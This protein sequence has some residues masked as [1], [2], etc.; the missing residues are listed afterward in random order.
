MNIVLLSISLLNFISSEPTDRIHN[1]R[2]VYQNTTEL[3]IVWESSRNLTNVR[4]SIHDGY[5]TD[6]DYAVK[7][8]IPDRDDSVLYS[9]LQPA[10]VY[11]ITINA[12]R[13]DG[14]PAQASTI[15]VYTL[16]ASAKNVRTKF[17]DDRCV[18]LE[19]ENVNQV[20][21]KVDCYARVQHTR[22]I[23]R[24]QECKGDQ[25]NMVRICDMP[26]GTSWDI[27]IW[28]ATNHKKSNTYVY[29]FITQPRPI[30]DATAQKITMLDEER[31]DLDIVWTWPEA[32]NHWG[33][34]KIV[35]SPPPIDNL[36]T[37]SPYFI[38]DRRLA[39]GHS[40]PYPSNSFRIEKIH[41]GNIYTV[42][43]S[44][45]KG[46]LES[47]PFC[48]EQ[49]IPRINP[50]LLRSSDVDENSLLEPTRRTCHIPLGLSPKKPKFELKVADI[51]PS[52]NITWE[53][54]EKK[55][56]ENGYELILAPEVDDSIEIPQ[57][58]HLRPGRD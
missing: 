25:Q 10:A 56:P 13:L 12:D 18:T 58:I 31:A 28:Y 49:A 5:E 15:K 24:N 27:N 19:W 22:D 32:G 21:E 7:T 33:L 52:M 57:I 11:W 9:G 1:V 41:Q 35:F 34:V 36:G 2:F 42:C 50:N 8:T 30:T 14:E 6:P 43:I 48:F 39:Y 47:E 26:P 54:P 20:R 51:E 3:G 29:R 4:T 23:W 53:Q 38:A 55:H 17:F 37:P 46:S 16:A 44:L 45:V 40:G